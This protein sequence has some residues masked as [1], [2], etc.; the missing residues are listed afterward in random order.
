MRAEL[1]AAVNGTVER[2]EWQARL[3]AGW[4]AG[5]PPLQRRFLLSG[6]D[7]VTRWLN[8]Y[9]DVPGALFEE[10]SY[11]VPGG[12]NLRA[13]IEAQPLVDGY[14][15]ANGS[16]GKADATEAGFWGRIDAFFEAA[17]TPGV[18]DRLGPEELN[19]EGALLFDWRQLPAGEGEARG[20]FLARVLEPP[21]LW[22]DAGF[23]LKG[24]YKRLGVAISLPLWASDADFAD[25]PTG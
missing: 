23:A 21:Q 6:A 22:A 15:S 18:P 1:D 11:F 16:I 14:L 4:A 10:I 25:A 8:P 19:A 17:W 13:Y 2:F 12:P 7:P 24:G 9:I 20:R 5:G 3:A